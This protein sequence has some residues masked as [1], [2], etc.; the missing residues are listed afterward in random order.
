MVLGRSLSV[1]KSNEQRKKPRFFIINPNRDRRSEERFESCEDVIL[2]FPDD[3]DR[4]AVPA[5][6]YDIGK[7]GLKLET[8]QPIEEG[9]D[10]QV[11]FAKSADNVRCFGLVRWARPMKG[12]SLFES[13]VIV[14]AWYGITQGSESYRQF[15]GTRTKKDRRNRDR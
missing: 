7:Q 3:K 14:S 12:D 4:K 1:M 9:T 8:T 6:A 5:I 13:G 10:I 2:T 11:V 15:K